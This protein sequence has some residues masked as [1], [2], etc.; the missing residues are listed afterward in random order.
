MKLREIGFQTRKNGEGGRSMSGM[1]SVRGK[2]GVRMGDEWFVERKRA[3]N[4]A[5]A[6]RTGGGEERDLG[7]G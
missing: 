5:E 4:E 7:N 6:G 1:K 3:G 2:G